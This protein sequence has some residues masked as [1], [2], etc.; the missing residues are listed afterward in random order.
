MGKNKWG[1]WM[2]TWVLDH[3]I[4]SYP[5]VR[6]LP[7]NASRKVKLLVRFEDDNKPAK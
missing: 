6:T 3:T 7:K 5:N 4:A 1:V 2:P